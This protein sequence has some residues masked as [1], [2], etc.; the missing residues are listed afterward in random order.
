[1]AQQQNDAKADTLSA[2]IKALREQVEKL[3]EGQ[4]EI[5]L[6]RYEVTGQDK[7]LSDTINR[8]G[9]VNTWLTIFGI[10]FAVFVAGVGIFAFVQAARRAK[11]EARDWLK[12][13]D[14]NLRQQITE[15]KAEAD[16]IKAQMTALAQGIKDEAARHSAN[17]G[18][19]A[20]EVQVL[21]QRTKEILAST[22]KTGRPMD[23]A[24]QQELHQADDHTRDKPESQY[25]AEDWNIRAHN[26]Y[27]SGA[28]DKA[29][30]FWGN[31]AETPN[32]TPI[33]IAQALFNKGVTLN[34]LGRWDEGVA[35]YDEIWQRFS[36]SSD[37]E[38]CEQTIIAQSNKGV[39]QG[40]RGQHENAIAT[41]D[42]I[43]QHFGAKTAP[44]LQ[45]AIANTICNRGWAKYRLG[46]DDGFL[47]D[48]ETARNR[49]S[50]HEAALCNRAFALLLIGHPHPDVL[51]A[52]RQAWNVVH[53]KSQWE[54]GPL[55][56][57]RAHGRT[58]RKDS[59]PVPDDLIEAVA[60][61]ALGAKSGDS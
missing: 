12:E 26:A 8:I 2:D 10:V 20:Q 36:M 1:M 24:V 17:M 61:L 15:M 38:L 14:Q 34:Q 47:R 49:L 11:D 46:D 21:S 22:I 41:F 48:S 43:E 35:A 32:A 50:N 31:I 52:Y 37:P 33:Q 54:K 19:A 42:T 9:D 28:L 40:R 60:A 53:D 45:N 16:G 27:V 23:S 59:S 44:R 3:S 13:N 51:D 18:D 55:A 56:D 4:R 58:V 29:A 7:R 25:T 39:V 5:P 30:M 6:L 57:L